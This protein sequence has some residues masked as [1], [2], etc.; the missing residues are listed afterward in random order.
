[1]SQKIKSVFLAGLPAIVIATFLVVAIIYAWI[2][3]TSPPPGGNV[4]APINV[5]DAAQIKIGPIQVNG[6]RNIGNTVLDGNVGIGTTT[7]EAK[8]DVSGPMRLLPMAEPFT[9]AAAKK[10][11]LYFNSGT[12]KHMM[13]NGAAWVDYTGPQ[14]T[15]GAPGLKGDKGD[16]GTPGLKGDKG[17]KGD[18]G[19]PG[20]AGGSITLSNCQWSFYYDIFHYGWCA[21]FGSG[22]VVVSVV[23][24]VAPSGPRGV[25]CCKLNFNPL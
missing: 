9:C 19:P 7:P 20:P 13:C 22:Y 12:N 1:M 4:A 2:E 18:I 10:G 24:A 8:L 16:P 6:F 11:T 15:P 25:E 17:D 21:G 3:P 14:G 23:D 5:G